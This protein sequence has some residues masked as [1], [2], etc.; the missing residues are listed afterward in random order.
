MEL[1]R[2]PLSLKEILAFTCTV[3]VGAA[4]VARFRSKVGWEVL[5]VTYLI[6]LVVLGAVWL[7]AHRHATTPRCIHCGVSWRAGS[8]FSQDPLSPM[9]VLMGILF[10]FLWIF[11]MALL[12]SAADWVVFALLNVIIIVGSVFGVFFTGGS[13]RRGSTS[14]GTRAAETTESRDR[15]VEGEGTPARDLE[16]DE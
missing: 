4:L 2:L 14:H 12:G 11:A 16:K 3:T 6:L 13:K 5:G 1:Q 15:I 7:A 8:V 9:A 10:L